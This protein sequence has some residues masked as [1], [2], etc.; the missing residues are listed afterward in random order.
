MGMWLGEPV[1]AEMV[2]PAYPGRQSNVIVNL[3]GGLVM[4]GGFI[5]LVM[6][7]LQISK[8]FF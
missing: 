2:E 5:G 3:L 1:S 6:I 8:L 7:A 4:L